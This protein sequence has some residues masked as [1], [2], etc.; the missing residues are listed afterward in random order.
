MLV[1]GIIT[2]V[3]SEGGL[4]DWSGHKTGGDGHAG[5]QGLLKVTEGGP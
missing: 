3:V 4:Q 2:S 1:G 5:L